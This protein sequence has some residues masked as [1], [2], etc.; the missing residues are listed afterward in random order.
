MASAHWSHTATLLPDGKVLVA[1]GNYDTVILAT[2]ELYD[3]ATGRWTATGSMAE[4][5][6]SHTATLLPNGKVLVAGGYGGVKHDRRCVGGSI[7]S[8]ERA[9]HGGTLG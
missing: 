1:G 3:P 7:Q 8:R 2:A 6:H 4:E 9:D 5:R